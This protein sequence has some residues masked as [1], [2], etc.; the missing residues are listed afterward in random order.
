MDGFEEA[1]LDHLSQAHSTET[2][3]NLM[4]ASRIVHSQQLYQHALQGL[5][6][7][8]P[9]PNLSQATRIGVKAYHTIM[10]AALS[11]ATVTI[12]SLTAAERASSSALAEAN[13]ELFEIKLSLLRPREKSEKRR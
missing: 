2:F 9:K 10:E 6:S 12:S 11:A 8:T 3:V 7:C 1:I 13:A 5:I 4:V